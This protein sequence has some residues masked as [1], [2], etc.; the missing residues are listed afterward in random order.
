MSG[1]PFEGAS[2]STGVVEFAFSLCGC[3]RE[4]GL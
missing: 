4:P 3:A 1:H 2:R